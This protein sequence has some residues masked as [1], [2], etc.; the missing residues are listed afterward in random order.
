MRLSAL[1]GTKILVPTMANVSSVQKVTS[2]A[3]AILAIAGIALLW[4][5]SFRTGFTSIEHAWQ[6][7]LA[8]IASAAAAGI[9]FASAGAF[10]D[11]ASSKI[12]THIRGFASLSVASSIFLLGA[13][14]QW[15]LILTIPASV[16]I[17]TLL[18]FLV[19]VALQP[20]KSAN[21]WSALILG[22]AFLLTSINFVAA[23]SIGDFPG[24]LVHWLQGD[25]LEAGN[26]SYLAL[27]LSLCLLAWLISSKS[28]ELPI[29]LLL[30]LGIGIAG[31][32]FFIGWLVPMLVR[33]FADLDHGALLVVTSGLIGALFVVSADAIP[34]LLIGG[35]SPGLAVPIA[36][37]SIP[38]LLWHQRL[39]LLPEFPSATRAVVEAGLILFWLVGFSFILYHI[40]HFASQAA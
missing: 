5:S 6:A 14:W 28:S 31:P 2:F 30:G 10:L 36:L 12:R 13:F 18:F 33:R 32:V 25:F 35:Y 4:M 40:V 34:R 26:Y 9:A 19:G 1:C 3:L 8:R 20:K 16:I 29:S 15:S 38:V 17:G 27:V 11:S 7:N 37:V 21:L 22:I 24:E 23:S 39:A